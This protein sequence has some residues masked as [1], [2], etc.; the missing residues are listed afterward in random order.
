MHW[1]WSVQYLLSE[2]VVPRCS[3]KKLFLESSQNSKE[4][5]SVRVSF[6]IK[7]LLAQILS[8]EFCEI[9]KNNFFHGTPSVAASILSKQF[10]LLLYYF[11]WMH[12]FKLSKTF[13]TFFFVNVDILCFKGLKLYC[14]SFKQLKTILSFIWTRF[15]ENHAEKNMFQWK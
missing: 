11:F 4:N 1:K 9:F 12:F 14:F 3:I 13:K 5:T 10:P 2:A 6:L 7:G 15:Y 8:C